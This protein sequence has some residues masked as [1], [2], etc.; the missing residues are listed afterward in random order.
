M[1]LYRWRFCQPSLR[2]TVL[3]R[4]CSFLV[5]EIWFD[6]GQMSC[7]WQGWHRW[8][9]I[10]ENLMYNMCLYWDLWLLMT[11]AK[12]IWSLGHFVG[13]IWNSGGDTCEKPLINSRLQ[14]KCP[15][16]FCFLGEAIKILNM[17]YWWFLKEFSVVFNFTIN[18]V[19]D[20]SPENKTKKSPI[21]LH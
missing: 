13:L 14:Q 10:R 11:E 18:L 6:S 16:C 12:K 7:N 19:S 8:D 2:N 21:S 17:F 20:V 3:L 9:S 5:Q 1:I 15:L 4:S